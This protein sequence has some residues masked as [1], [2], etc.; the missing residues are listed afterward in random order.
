[1]TMQK[2][3]E[4][5][6]VS[7]A[8]VSAVLNHRWQEV[9]ISDET[10]K[11]IEV[12]I[13]ENHY[14]PHTIGQALVMR[15]SLTVG[16]ILPTVGGSFTPMIVQGI[17]DIS[18]ARGYGVLMMTTRYQPERQEKILNFMLER[19]IDGVIVE[20]SLHVGSSM[21][22]RLLE[23]ELPIVEMSSRTDDALPTSRFV[24]TDGMEIGRLGGR[25]LFQ[26]GHRHIAWIGGT[27]YG[28]Y[29]GIQATAGECSEPT[30][31]EQAK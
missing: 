31:V 23:M 15:R 26:G 25:R 11:R 12:I 7:R 2:V 3:A 17:E 8:A 18:E 6:G 1:M 16:L 30:R 4:L 19:N 20:P 29:D 21:R 24:C 14:I 5:A 22:K 27:G 13:E 9:R 28:V 10:R